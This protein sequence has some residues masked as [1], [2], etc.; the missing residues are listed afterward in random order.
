MTVTLIAGALLA[1]ALDQA[2][3]HLA[4]ARLGRGRRADLAPWLRLRVAAN[5]GSFLWLGRSPGA[6][7][8]WWAATLA[9][10]VAVGRYVTPLSD[11]VIQLA[12]G[13]AVGGATGNLVDRLRHGF[14]IDLIDIRIARWWWPTF[15]VADAAIVLG[16][17]VALWALMR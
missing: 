15:N 7:L 1:L 9:A 8:A 4:L 17:A 6:Q 5:P 10:V 11:P 2:T 13:I 14:V 3:K 12:L 16:V